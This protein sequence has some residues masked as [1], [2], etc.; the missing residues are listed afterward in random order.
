MEAA[1]F[2]LDRTVIARSSMMAF[3]RAF[4]R[5][6]LLSKRAA[7]RSAW[8][9]L[10][11]TRAG[12][13]PEELARIRAR[14]LQV[15]TGWPQ[16][17]VRRI[18]AAGL[19]D[20]IAPIVY[21]EAAELLAEHRRAGRLVYL[22]S[23]APEEIVEPIG[24]HLGVDGVVASRAY[25]DGDGCYLGT[26]ERYCYG[27][28]KA[29]SVVELAAR[30]GIDLARSW[31]YSDSATDVPMLEVVGHP[32]AV[33]P[34]RALRDVAEARGWPVLDFRMLGP[35]TGEELVAAIDGISDDGPGSTGRRRWAWPALAST[36][37]V[38]TTTGGV[39]AWLRRRGSLPT[40]T[41]RS[42]T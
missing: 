16:A 32:V 13:G 38:V 29:D 15:T 25:L 42:S 8:T 6:G 5:A 26:L 41:W 31:A 30:L 39:A 10:R 20:A 34:D 40:P 2:D 4:Q 7:L 14:V 37:A 9:H 18:V 36:A 22:V 28:A 12:A 35:D 33:N 11:F 24:G 19:A 17:D 27:P 3:A 21:R 1:F 23:A